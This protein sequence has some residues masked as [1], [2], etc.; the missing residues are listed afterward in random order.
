MKYTKLQQSLNLNR[1]LAI[2]GLIGKKELNELF[3][4]YMLLFMHHNS[5]Y[6]KEARLLSWVNIEN[7]HIIVP[8]DLAKRGNDRH[9]PITTYSDQIL[10]E[11]L[12][13]KQ[14]YNLK[15]PFIFT[16]TKH[17]LTRTYSSLTC[18]ALLPIEMFKFLNSEVNYTDFKM[19]LG[20]DLEYINLK[21]DTAALKQFLDKE[22]FSKKLIREQA[23]VKT[24]KMSI[25]DIKKL[26]HKK[27]CE[28]CQQPII[29]KGHIDHCHVTGKVRGRLCPKCNHGLGNFRDDIKT[30]RSAIRYLERN[31]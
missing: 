12:W 24:Y 7:Q 3:N 5:M 21:I 27:S 4:C 31:I 26:L 17:P 15:S 22:E 9:I 2:D 14:Q 25:D 10:K 23:A 29:R 8:L 20:R 1:Q 18:K 6:H 11:V 16:H 19:I 28:I 30:L 13:I